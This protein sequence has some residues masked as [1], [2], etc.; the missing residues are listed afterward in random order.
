MSFSYYFLDFFTGVVVSFISSIPLGPVGLAV[1][2]AAIDGDRKK[3]AYIA[4]GSALMEGI[5]CAI[6]VM[7]FYSILQEHQILEYI[8]MG[9]I[10]VLLAFGGYNL[11]K[12]VPRSY[13][14]SSVKVKHAF[15]KGM[16]LC[17]MNPILIPYWIGITAYLGASRWL[18]NEFPYLYAYVGGVVLGTFGLMLLLG[19]LTSVSVLRIGYSLRVSLTRI[20]G[21]VFIG[22]GIFTLIKL[23]F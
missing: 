13:E 9:S 6:A 21:I 14:F 4:A 12:K 19:Y 20:I 18:H 7:G 2:Q 11:F 16:F 22:F 15:L 10:P 23:F 17:L 3:S 1:V 5:Y 8:Q